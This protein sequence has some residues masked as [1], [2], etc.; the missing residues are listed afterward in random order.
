MTCSSLILLSLLAQ[1]PI[2]KAPAPPAKTPA[3]A[4]KKSVAPKTASG[5]NANVAAKTGV[6]PKPLPAKVTPVKPKVTAVA[7]PLTTD[8]Q[9]T[10]YTI[11]LSIAKSLA[12]FELTP[13]EFEL[14]KRGLSDA[15][16]KT[17]AVDLMEWGPKIQELA[18]ARQARGAEKEKVAS[19]AYLIKAAGELGAVKT[20]SGII[21]KQLKAGT[22]ASPKATDTVKVHYRGTLTDGTEFDSSYKRNEPA[23]FGL[24]QV[25]KCWTEGVQ[26]MK[27]G[28]K[29]QLV[30][31]S[32]L[33]YGD[34]GRP[35]IPGGATL[36]FEIELLEIA[37]STPP[38]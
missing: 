25:I 18:K 26:K 23:S 13:A 22:G 5:P 34:Q 16:A 38:E 12:P 33:A 6:A 29:A 21:Y 11:G 9:K 27:V 19:A 15:G 17:P 32:G 30:C 1:A 3:D 36:I 4:P 20:D 37:A 7:A 28:E 10:L 14:V 8:E 31:P 2:V 24:N 35:S